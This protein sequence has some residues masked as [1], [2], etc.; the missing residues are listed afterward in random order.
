VRFRTSRFADLTAMR[1]QARALLPSLTL[2]GREGA[3]ARDVV[4]SSKRLRFL[5]AVGLSYLA[6]DRAAPTL[7][8]A[9]KRYGS[10][11]SWLQTSRRVQSST[12]R[13]SACTARQ[14]VL[15]DTQDRCRRKA[16]PGRRG[17]RRDTIAGD[18]RHRPRPGAGKLGGRVIARLGR[19]SREESRSLSGRFSRT[20][21]STAACPPRGDAQT[22][23]STS[24]APA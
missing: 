7:S 21:C 4:A 16:I 10:P 24:R 9:N 12:S 5:D 19:R 23:G 8:A 2:N 14:F 18:A 1:R 11:R 22:P 13:R 3:I 20:R 17:A 15:L 6:L